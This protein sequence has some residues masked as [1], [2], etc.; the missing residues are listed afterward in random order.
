MEQKIKVPVIKQNGYK[1]TMHKQSLFE[2]QEKF[3]LLELLH[4]F[5]LSRLRKNEF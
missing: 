5:S 4:V 3:S 1:F 2:A